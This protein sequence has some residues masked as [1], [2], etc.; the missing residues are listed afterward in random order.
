MAA[1]EYAYLDLAPPPGETYFYRLEAVGTEGTTYFGPVSAEAWF[2]IFVPL[3]V[4]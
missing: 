3:V 1:G 4:R 2:D